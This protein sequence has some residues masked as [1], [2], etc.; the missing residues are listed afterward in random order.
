VLAACDDEKDA[1]SAAYQVAMA[2]AHDALLDG[3]GQ[4][5]HVVHSA[6]QAAMRGI[7][8]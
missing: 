6:R 8:K 1:N 3:P 2:N 5:A 4:I 7:R